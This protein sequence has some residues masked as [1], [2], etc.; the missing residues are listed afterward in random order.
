M[1]GL[2][3]GILLFIA[4]SVYADN[5]ETWQTDHTVHIQ[6]FY[7]DS[8]RHLD[9][10]QG[11]LF[12]VLNLAGTLNYQ[13]I[14][15]KV[16]IIAAYQQEDSQNLLS[17]QDR[18]A[19]IG[20]NWGSGFIR[21]GRQIIPSGK[22]DILNPTDI[23][24]PFNYTRMTIDDDLQ[25]DGRAAIRLRQDLANY[26]INLMS[27]YDNRYQVLP[28]PEGTGLNIIED[29]KQREAYALRLDYSSQ[30]IDVGLLFYTGADLQP[31]FHLSGLMAG[32]IQQTH[33]RTDL[34]GVDA[35]GTV[36]GIAWRAEAACDQLKQDT[37][38][39]EWVRQP[40]CQ[41]AMGADYSIGENNFLAQVTHL[42]IRDWH[43]PN[44][45]LSRLFATLTGQSQAEET[46]VTARFMRTWYNDTIQTELPCSYGVR[47]ADWACRPRIYWAIQDH[48]KLSLGA[49]VF[50]GSE[51]GYL[52][53]LKKNNM[54]LI[55]FNVQY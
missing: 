26:T 18:E 1:R 48:L 27:F 16:D 4:H 34:V 52:G 51:Y 17:L 47:A 50:S 11:G 39:T 13:Q 30:Y 8:N 15:A 54:V 28:M 14:Q 43:A 21:A 35:T 19:F 23:L 22:V 20:L 12:S 2:N 41:I 49:D 7:A 31:A 46:I 44:N 24:T 10:Q 5:T 53:R 3:L 25:R 36:N 55:G 38:I 6:S 40:Q 42:N 29:K 45:D 9:N 37:T 33:H 32:I